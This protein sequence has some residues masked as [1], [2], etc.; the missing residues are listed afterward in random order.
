MNTDRYERIAACRET[1]ERNKKQAD[2]DGISVAGGIARVLVYGVP[3]TV[4]YVYFWMWLAYVN[5]PL[6]LFIEVFVFMLLIPFGLLWLESSS[7][8]KQR[9]AFHQARIELAG[10]EKEM[11]VERNQ[12]LL[13][14]ST[15]ESELIRAIAA[16]GRKKEEERDWVALRERCL[17]F[18]D[19][20]AGKGVDALKPYEILK[21]YLE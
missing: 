10:L 21:Q 1:M 17:V 2:F 12:Q 3:L 14:Y 5:Y 20:W 9:D 13:E 16:E 8:R 7:R 15:A 19:A 4:L 11:I 18:A 6:F